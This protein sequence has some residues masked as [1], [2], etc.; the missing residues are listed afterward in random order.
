MDNTKE[1]R[2]LTPNEQKEALERDK[3]DYM[4]QCIDEDRK[5]SSN[6]FLGFWGAFSG[7]LGGSILYAFIRSN[8]WVSAWVGFFMAVM[9]S[10]CYDA[11]KVKRNIN[12]LYCVAAACIIAVPLGEF[13]GSIIYMMHEKALSGYVGMF[14][15]YYVNNFGKFLA[16]SAD[17]LFL[18]YVFTAIG[19]AKV[20][21]DIKDHDTEMEKMEEYLAEY[22]EDA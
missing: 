11:L 15:S 22:E 4:R 19:S 1:I 5:L 10:K 13:L 16:D 9:A 18:G 14:F 8:G 20:F 17:N 21:K 12:K 2:Y 6:Y 7:A 3:R